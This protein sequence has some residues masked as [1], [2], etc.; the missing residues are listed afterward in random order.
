MAR[1]TMQ[2]KLTAVQERDISSSVLSDEGSDSGSGDSSCDDDNS[3]IELQPPV[4]SAFIVM[5]CVI[6]GY[7]L[8][9]PLQ[10]DLKHELHIQDTGLVGSYFTQSVALVQWGKTFTSL[11]QNV[12]LGCIPI[13]TRV[14]VSMGLMFVGVL[15]PPMFIFTLGSKWLGWIPLSYG[16]IGLSLGVFECT[17][18]S[19]I[20]PLGPKTKSWAI[21]GFPA[22]FGIVNIVGGSLVAAFEMPVAWTFWYIVACQPVAVMLFRRF[23]PDEQNKVDGRSYKQA[24]LRQSLR[25]WRSWLLRIIPFVLVNILSHFVMESVLPAVFNTF[26]AKEVMLLGPTDTRIRMKKTW[27]LVVLFVFIAA[28]DMSSRRIGYCFRFDTTAKNYAGLLFV[29]SCNVFGLYLSS[30]GIGALTWFAVGIAIFGSGFNYAVCSKYIDQRVPRKHN[31][32]AYSLWMC[33][34]Y[35][36]AIAGAVLVDVVRGWF[37]SE[38]VQEYQC[39]P[40]SHH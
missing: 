12:L 23:A 19:V 6:G 5:T 32:A 30:F 10:H 28:A 17:F 29:L 1:S 27:F 33:V 38:G 20:S 2:V 21:M 26:N 14:Y 9:G 24:G 4:R 31:L 25:D 11:A 13:V 40:G 34:G 37:C 18:L 15:I 3:C 7:T 22:A 36:G 39:T 8:I 16:L 35:L